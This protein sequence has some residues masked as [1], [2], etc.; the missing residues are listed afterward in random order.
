MKLLTP[1]H[2]TKKAKLSNPCTIYLVRHGETDW[3]KARKLQG[4]KDIPLN[5]IGKEQ[6]LK[7]SDELK[8]IK[9]DAIF[10]SDL[11]RAKETAE[12]IAKRRKLIVKTSELLRERRLGKLE[13]S[14]FEKFRD[15]FFSAYKSNSPKEILNFEE[16]YDLEK[17]PEFMQKV[18][19]FI[20]EVALAYRNKKVLMVT[21]GGTMRMILVKVGIVTLP[22]HVRIKIDN[23]AYIKILTDGDDIYLDE[24]KGI[25]LI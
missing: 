21:H 9:F 15:E 22:N 12:I 18:I 2:S 4:W 7:L 25:S 19:V 23:T 5:R 24:L 13:G 14:K 1:S 6:A 17:L 8:D 20:K 3:N 11:L 10:S 16:K